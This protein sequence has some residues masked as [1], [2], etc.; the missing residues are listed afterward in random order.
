MEPGVCVYLQNANSQ[1]RRLDLV[2][3]IIYLK[4]KSIIYSKNVW[5]QVFVYICKMQIRQAGGLTL[6]VCIQKVPTLLPAS[7]A[8]N[9]H[10]IFQVFYTS[11]IMQNF[12]EENVD[13]LMFKIQS[14]RDFDLYFVTIIS[15]PTFITPIY[16][17]SFILLVE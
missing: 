1:G 9:R 4:K 6:W 2:L 3:Y 5:D 7:G 13:H 8:P 14:K 11:D 15:I 17:K 12:S 16:H 10:A